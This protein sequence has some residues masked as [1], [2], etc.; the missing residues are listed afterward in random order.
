MPREFV[1][2]VSG[3]YLNRPVVFLISN[4]LLGTPPDTCSNVKQSF[5]FE[6]ISALMTRKSVKP[7]QRG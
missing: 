4:F 6:T 7:Q 1:L 3:L 5:V 2:V